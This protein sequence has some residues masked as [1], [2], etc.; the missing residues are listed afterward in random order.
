M[1]PTNASTEVEAPRDRIPHSAR[2]LNPMPTFLPPSRLVSHYH[3]IGHARAD[4]RSTPRPRAK[5]WQTRQIID[6]LNPGLGR[7]SPMSCFSA[8][9]SNLAWM[10]TVCRWIGFAL[11]TGDKP[12][13]RIHFYFVRRVLQRHKSPH[14]PTT[15]WIS[16]ARNQEPVSRSG[17]RSIVYGSTS[18]MYGQV[19]IYTVQDARCAWGSIYGK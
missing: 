8:V 2:E 3:R 18:R 1:G 9:C 15:A 17:L 6:P 7:C 4:S 19:S 16:L 10:R 13:A 11:A 14:R 5:F 12:L